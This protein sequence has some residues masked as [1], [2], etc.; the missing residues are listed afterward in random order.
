MIDIKNFTA[1]G[2]S[3]S[4]G[5][6]TGPYDFYAL[7]GC[8]A[9]MAY[10]DM[11]LGHPVVDFNCKG[12]YIYLRYPELEDTRQY[13]SDFSI[14]YSLPDDEAKY[15][16]R[17]V[18][19][20]SKQYDCSTTDKLAMRDFVDGSSRYLANEV[21]YV[22]ASDNSEICS[23]LSN[24]MKVC[25]YRCMYISRRS[26]FP[27]HEQA[28]SHMD[29]MGPAVNY[30]C[31]EVYFDGD[32][33]VLLHYRNMYF[34]DRARILE[35]LNGLFSSK[36]N[37]TKQQ[38]M[39]QHNYQVCNQNFG[40]N[41]DNLIEFIRLVVRSSVKPICIESSLQILVDLE[42]NMF[43]C[44]GNIGTNLEYK[45]NYTPL[46]I[47]ALNAVLTTAE[48]YINTAKG[49]PHDY[50]TFMMAGELLRSKTKGI[51]LGPTAKS[52][53]YDNFVFEFYMSKSFKAIA[54]IRKSPDGHVEEAATLSLHPNTE[55]V[56]ASNSLCYMINQIKSTYLTN[57]KQIE[58]SAKTIMDLAGAVGTVQSTD[59]KVSNPTQAAYDVD[60]TPVAYM[61]PVDAQG[62]DAEYE[63]ITKALMSWCKEAG[64][65]TD[66]ANKLSDVLYNR[67]VKAY[68]IIELA[69]ALGGNVTSL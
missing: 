33:G 17:D 42:D 23:F 7:F 46:E 67:K 6:A 18:E 10:R 35:I 60:G 61:L 68:A 44:I 43:V 11:K 62:E 2:Q 54:C 5:D 47:S 25:N 9:F 64:I 1:K 21:D 55:L 50:N 22:A 53:N 28:V 20:R 63:T 66:Y 13:L 15:V 19:L 38:I 26:L 27:N 4:L 59:K 32:K 57:T 14:T 69:R 16:I 65:S 29:L 41:D 45:G 8:V 48:K 24:L 36:S 51:K 31:P 39:S 37:V 52:F 40:L 49:R 3:L 30:E 56:Q 34:Y 12:R 58:L